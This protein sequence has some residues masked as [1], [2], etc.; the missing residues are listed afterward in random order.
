MDD[1]ITKFL[2]GVQYQLTEM[3]AHGLYANFSRYDI[4]VGTERYGPHSFRVP[5]GNAGPQECL[6]DLQCRLLPVHST[7]R[8]RRVLLPEL[9]GAQPVGRV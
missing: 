2:R 9:R 7:D 6:A 1:H 8:Q 3:Q 5:P 4:H